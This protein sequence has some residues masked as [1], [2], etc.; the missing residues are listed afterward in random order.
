M[1]GRCKLAELFPGNFLNRKQQIVEL[2][3]CHHD[4]QRQTI[5]VPVNLR[6]GYI[7]DI[8]LVTIPEQVGQNFGFHVCNPERDQTSTEPGII[9][10]EYFNTINLS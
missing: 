6:M 9:R 8:D 7:S 3:G 10:G 5:G 4:M 1:L 2:F